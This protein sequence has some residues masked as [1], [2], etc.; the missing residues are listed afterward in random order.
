MEDQKTTQSIRK[1]ILFSIALVLATIF[2]LFFGFA[3]VPKI[4]GEYI[5]YFSGESLHNAGWEGIVMELTFYVFLTGY[6]FVW[7]KKCTGGIIILLASVIQMGPFLI[8]DGN[9]GSLIFG[10][11]M[12][13]VGV[14]FMISCKNTTTT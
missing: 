7:W 9:L 14:L 4:I 8:I 10:L 6:I 12:L 5:G 11:P 3:I 13:I 2:V 1:K